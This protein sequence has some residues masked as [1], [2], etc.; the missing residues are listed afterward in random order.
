MIAKTTT[1]MVVLLSLKKKW[2]EL[3]QNRE[4]FGPERA[5]FRP[6]GVGHQQDGRVRHGAIDGERELFGRGR[7]RKR[8]DRE[9]SIVRARR[10]PLDGIGMDDAQET[11]ESCVS[12]RA[13]LPRSTSSPTAIGSMQS[14]WNAGVPRARRRAAMATSASS[15]PARQLTMDNGRSPV[16]TAGEVCRQRGPSRT[17]RLRSRGRR[18]AR[19]SSCEWPARA[20]RRP[21]AR[22]APRRQRQPSRPSPSP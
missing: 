14:M 5:T 21:A 1:R 4:G 22:A 12:G 2:P 6:E 13:F 9:V 20:R 3:F 19:P 11:F 18:V 10:P 16:A 17:R 15:D 8:A 7:G